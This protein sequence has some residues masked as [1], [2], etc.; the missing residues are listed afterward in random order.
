MKMAYLVMHTVRGKQIALD[1]V[2]YGILRA[3]HMFKR[4]LYYPLTGAVCSKRST[5]G[6]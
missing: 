3:I 6:V 2:G 1:I 4:S 5:D